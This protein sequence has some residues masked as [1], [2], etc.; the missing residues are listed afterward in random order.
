M[1]LGNQYRK[2]LVGFTDGIEDMFGKFGVKRL[3]KNWVIFNYVFLTIWFVLA[4]VFFFVDEPIIHNFMLT[5]VS[6]IAM[7]VFLIYY[8]ILI[9]LNAKLNKE[10]EEPSHL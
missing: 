7:S 3:G 6:P 10:L 1:R 4:C 8:I 2:C 5:I 9:A